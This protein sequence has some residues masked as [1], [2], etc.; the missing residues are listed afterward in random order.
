M[1]KGLLTPLLCVLSA[2]VCLAQDP[3]N[4][5]A[6]AVFDNTSHDFGLVA[7][8]AKLEHR[9]TV[10]NVF[11]EDLRIESVQST[12]ECT[13]ATFSKELVKIHQ[14]AEI[15]ARIDTRNFVGRKEATLRVKLAE[16][17]P[18]EVQL[19]LCCDIRNDVVFE[20]GEIQFGSVD[21][22]TEGR[23]KIVV[24]YAGRPDWRIADVLTSSP[25]LQVDLAEV[26][27]TAGQ[28][29]YDLWATLKGD[30]PTGYLRDHLIL[31]TNDTD[32]NA[33]RVPLAVGGVVV[34]VVSAGPSPLPLGVVQ[35]GE[36][37]TRNLVVRGKVPFR[38]LSV[39]CPDE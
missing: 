32:P 2:E 37:I 29:T 20:P 26:S 5:W 21:Q 12:C 39:T 24:R 34:P 15:I 31:V 35:V 33:S 6:K 38:I 11:P 1:Y 17:F 25:H 16:P 18:V 4:D 19:H 36:T 13:S 23:R 3:D 28:V 14:K 22:G 8:G 7:R 10:E 30:A 27:R 9:F